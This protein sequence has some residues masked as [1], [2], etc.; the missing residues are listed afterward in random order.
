MD[1]QSIDD[2]PV[3]DQSLATQVICQAATTER[4]NYTP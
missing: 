1:C 2:H 4:T 3:E